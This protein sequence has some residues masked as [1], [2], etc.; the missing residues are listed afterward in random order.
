MSTDN[1]PT[2]PTYY[3]KVDWASGPDNI[4]PSTSFRSNKLNQPVK[5]CLS[6]LD[7]NKF[8]PLS[9]YTIFKRT[10]NQRTDYPALAFKKSNDDPN[11]TFLSYS[12]YWKVCQKAAKS[13]IKVSLQSLAYI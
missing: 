10:V 6:E 7:S 5:L 13:F 11:F 12:E 9:I 1:I 4:C 3:T 2:L 8:P